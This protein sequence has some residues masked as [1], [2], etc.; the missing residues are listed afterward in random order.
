MNDRCRPADRTG[1]GRVRRTGDACTDRRGPSARARSWRPTCP[2]AHHGSLRHGRG[3][4]QIVTQRTQLPAH[5]NVR[6]G[7][8]VVAVGRVVKVDAQQ[9][10]EH[11]QGR[12]VRHA[13]QTAPAAS[14]FH[15][16]RRSPPAAGQGGGPA[17]PPVGQLGRRGVVERADGRPFR[18]V[19]AVAVHASE[20]GPAGAALARLA[21]P[22][23]VDQLAE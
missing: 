2:L 20:S 19:E 12:Q 6:E 22:V 5:E 7:G 11:G 1:P 16:G 4:W 23:R 3:R 15:R 9:C 18:P 8:G 14:R 10:G 17:L 21:L 13:L